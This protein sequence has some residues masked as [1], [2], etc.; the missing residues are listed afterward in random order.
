[1]SMLLH[2]CH[3]LPNISRQ[4]S[5]WKQTPQKQTDDRCHRTVR[6][7][8]TDQETPISRHHRWLLTLSYSSSAALRQRL[9]TA[10]LL[11]EPSHVF[12]LWTPGLTLD[13]SQRYLTGKKTKNNKPLHDG[14]LIM[15]SRLTASLR[16]CKNWASVVSTRHKRSGSRHYSCLK[17][18]NKCSQCVCVCVR[19]RARKS[20]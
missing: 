6:S 7:T 15:S 8:F 3:D 14:K 19:V 12:T 1:M 5:S 13:S 4:T 20:I 18:E 17:V 2:S 11:R 16:E 9:P 10:D